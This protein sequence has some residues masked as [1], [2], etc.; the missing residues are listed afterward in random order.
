[1][2]TDDYACSTPVNFSHVFAIICVNISLEILHEIFI[3][4]QRHI[5]IYTHTCKCTYTY[6]YTDIYILVYLF[7]SCNR[8]GIS[9]Q[10]RFDPCCL[11]LPEY[12]WLVCACL[13]VCNACTY[14]CMKKVLNLFVPNGDLNIHT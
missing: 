12:L 2:H 9:N 11:H 3:H 14:L 4:D 13:F 8:R 6:T 1:M 10:I 7:T 5:Y